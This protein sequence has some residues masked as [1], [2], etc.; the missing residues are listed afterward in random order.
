MAGSMCSLVR[1]D[2]SHVPTRTLLLQSFGRII[3]GRSYQALEV[4][5]EGAASVCAFVRSDGD[6]MVIV[7]VRLYASWP[8]KGFAKRARVE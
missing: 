4:E 3:S 5:G 8:E 7:A 2:R 1:L 6:Q